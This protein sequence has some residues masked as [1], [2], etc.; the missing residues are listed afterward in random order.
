MSNI[1]A[2]LLINLSLARRAQIASKFLA[3]TFATLPKTSSGN[4]RPVL[5]GNFFVTRKTSGFFE[6]RGRPVTNPT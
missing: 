1:D 2:M 6:V 5:H 4:Y 3:T